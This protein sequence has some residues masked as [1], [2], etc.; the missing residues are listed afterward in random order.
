MTNIYYET[1]A[2]LKFIQDKTIAIIG[3]GS[4]GHAHAR[5]LHDSGIKVVVGLRE[6]SAF[7]GRAKKDGLNVMTVP[8]ATK[9]ADILMILIPD[10]LRGPP[11]PDAQ[12]AGVAG[13][14]WLGPG[15]PADRQWQPAREHQQGFHHRHPAP[16][17][18]HPGPGDHRR[19]FLRS[20]WKLFSAW[21]AP[22]LRKTD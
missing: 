20:V 7:W 10:E 8:E 12:A 16:D 2:D 21:A 17:C 22:P 4:Q 13:R 6:G 19:R 9:T 1:Q 3:Y 18:T 14:Q 15:R 11:L 5:N